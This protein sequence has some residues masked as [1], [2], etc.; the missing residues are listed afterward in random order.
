[1]YAEF[2][3]SFIPAWPSG[4]AVDFGSTIPGS[5]PGAGA[6]MTPVHDALCLAMKRR[7]PARIAHGSH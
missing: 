6:S 7:H 5:N 3:S 2:F 4:K 1:V